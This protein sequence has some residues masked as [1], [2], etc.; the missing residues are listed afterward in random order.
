MLEKLVILFL[1]IG[2]ILHFIK[3]ATGDILKGGRG[4]TNVVFGATQ[5]LMSKD[6]R[7]AAEVI[8]NKNAGVKEEEQASGEPEEGNFSKA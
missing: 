6:Q 8:V 4:S 5:D 7:K 2:G 3:V 1:A